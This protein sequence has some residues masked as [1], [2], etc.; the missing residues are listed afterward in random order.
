MWQLMLNQIDCSLEVAEENTSDSEVLRPLLKDVNFEDALVDGAYDTNDEFE[1]MK[2][3]GAD[4]PGIKTK[5][6]AVV[7]KE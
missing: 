2:L 6:N 7:G 5:G 3:N 1:F 4:Y